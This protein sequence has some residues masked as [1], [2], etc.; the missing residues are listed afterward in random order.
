MEAEKLKEIRAH[1]NEIAKLGCT[2]NA[3]SLH[4][5][6][7]EVLFVTPIIKLIISLYFKKCKL[8]KSTNY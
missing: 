8:P 3:F 5:K 1:A 7:S 6:L 2:L 4:K